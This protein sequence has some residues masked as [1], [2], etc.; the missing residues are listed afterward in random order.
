MKK[1]PATRLLEPS[2]PRL[3]T[4]GQLIGWA[5]F[6]G[7]VVFGFVFGVVI[8]YEPPRSVVV[9][10]AAN[11]PKPSEGPDSKKVAPKK[12]QPATVPRESPRTKATEAP[13][14]PPKADPPK[15]DPPGIGARAAPPLP[16]KV[17]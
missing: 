5:V 2:S 12:E 3:S 16:K 4:R 17:E 1:K 11:E 15:V 8:G 7:L 10:R 14:D 9:A 13:I 6:G